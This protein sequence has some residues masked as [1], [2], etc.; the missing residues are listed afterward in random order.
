MRRSV[1]ESCS[2]RRSARRC[3]AAP[4]AP[5]PTRGARRAARRSRLPVPGTRGRRA[6]AAPGAGRFRARAG[7]GRARRGSLLEAARARPLPP[8]ATRSPVPV[9][10]RGE[11]KAAAAVERAGGEPCRPSAARRRAARAA[12]PRGEGRR[13]R[14]RASI[15]AEPASWARYRPAP[16]R[17]EEAA[18]PAASSRRHRRR[19]ARAPRGCDP[20][21]EGDP[22][23]TCLPRRPG[24]GRGSALRAFSVV[25]PVGVDLGEDRQAQRLE[26]L[27]PIW[28]VSSDRLVAKSRGRVPCAGGHLRLG[29]VKQAPDDV[30]VGPLR[31]LGD[32]RP[33]QSARLVVAVG[34]AEQECKRDARG[35]QA[36][37]QADVPGPPA[38]GRVAVTIRVARA[39]AHGRAGHA[40]C[41]PCAQNADLRRP[42][43][44][45]QRQVAGSPSCSASARPASA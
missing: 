26:H 20:Q 41:D 17:R 25:T 14:C 44:E 29:A 27:Q 15:P 9:A 32:Q 42:P 8:R 18:W 12:A 35:R 19:R 39:P 43:A 1:S 2:R 24:A 30:G 13:S 7:S 11:E 37:R 45:S 40:G 4:I 34:S 10:L 33:P 5:S 22:I 21:A 38:C 16:R 6:C 36:H 3:A 31:G 28:R 23:R